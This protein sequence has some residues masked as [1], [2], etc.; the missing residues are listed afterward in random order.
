MIGQIIKK[1]REC[2]GMTA[3]ELCEK[4][5]VSTGRLSDQ[6]NEKKDLTIDE[7]FKIDKVLD[8]DIIWELSSCYDEGLN[9]TH[10]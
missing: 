1:T 6:E 5:G 3:S 4:S 8:H 7:L 10:K 9:D 2:Y